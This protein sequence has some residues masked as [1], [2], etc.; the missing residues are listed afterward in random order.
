MTQLLG[1]VLVVLL[2]GTLL[3]RE[4]VGLGLLRTSMLAKRALNRSIV[5]LSTAFVAVIT[6]HLVN[7]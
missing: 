6:L 4:A 3:L 1:T 5:V 7:L 2:V